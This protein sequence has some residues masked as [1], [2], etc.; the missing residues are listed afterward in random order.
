[1]EHEK[2]NTVSRMQSSDVVN[3]DVAL[4]FL[5]YNKVSGNRLFY[6]DTMLIKCSDL[7]LGSNFWRCGSYFQQKGR[8]AVFSGVSFNSN[9]VFASYSFQQ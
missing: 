9:S 8:A 4:V 5:L 3:S 1:M 6:P 2:P 7:C